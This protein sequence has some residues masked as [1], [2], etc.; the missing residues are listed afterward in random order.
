MLSQLGSKSQPEQGYDTL[1][2]PGG[3][4][5]SGGQGQR[6]SIARAIVTD[7]K[8]LLLDEATSALDSRSERVVQVSTG[9]GEQA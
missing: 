3:V 4:S 9:G 8:V 7:P 6:L 2:G 1:L 5:L